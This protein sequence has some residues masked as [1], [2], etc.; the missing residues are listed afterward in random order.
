MVFSMLI[1][2]EYGKKEKRLETS[3]NNKKIHEP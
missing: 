2:G 1:S 3:D